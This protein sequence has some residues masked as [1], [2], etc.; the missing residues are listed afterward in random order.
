MSQAAPACLR[1]LQQHWQERSLSGLTGIDWLGTA[2]E[3][4]WL[5]EQVEQER[6]ALRLLLNGLALE[7][8]VIGIAVANGPENLVLGLALVLE[9]IA[10]AILPVTATAT[11][12]IQLA[13]RFGLSH[14]FGA[15]PPADP[16]RW[17]WLGITAQGIPCW[18]CPQPMPQPVAT[19]VAKQ[20]RLLLLGTTSGTTNGRPALVWGHSTQV[21]QQVL[22]QRWLPFQLLRHPM[23]SPELQNWS[24]R[25]NKLRALLQGQGL[26]VRSSEQALAELP[27]PE[28]CDGTLIGPSQLRR[29]LARGDLNHCPEGFLLLSGSDRVPMELRRA[30]IKAAPVRLGITYATS[31]TGPLTWLPPEA[32]LEEVDSVGWPLPDVTIELLEDGIRCERDGQIF[33]EAIMRTPTQSLNPGDLLHISASGQVIFGGRANDVFLFNSVLIS[34]VEIEDALQRHP[35]VRDCAAFGAASQRYGSVPMAAIIPQPGWS[36]A[37]LLS[38][39]DGFCREALG[40]RRPRR[41]ILMDHIPRGATGKVLRR[42]LAAQHSLQQ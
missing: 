9:G 3:A 25:F 23:V 32:V 37:A 33:R 20:G 2:L 28:A 5:Q 30:V 1:E 18:R 42:E 15:E 39:L 36:R 38:D 16:E 19:D 35:G 10:Q 11:E 31:Q 13:Q 27:L 24:G 8:L 6:Q 17:Q 41:F 12:Q 7:E 40:T 14:R 21:L 22:L 34:P 4:A 26:T 29:R